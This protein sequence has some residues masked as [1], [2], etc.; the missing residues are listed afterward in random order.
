MNETPEGSVGTEERTR[1]EEPLTILH[2]QG[3]QGRGFLL[4]LNAFG[5]YSGSD[6]TANGNNGFNHSLVCL[7]NVKV[8]HEPRIDLQIRRTQEGH[9]FQS[10]ITSAATVHR[11]AYSKVRKSCT[12]RCQ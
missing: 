10:V 7:A 11:K 5:D 6:P 4:G 9:G 2:E 8:T 1:E 12:Y 3:S